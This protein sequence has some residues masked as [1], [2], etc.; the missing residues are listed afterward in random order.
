[1]KQLKAGR[2]RER[3]ETKKR[4]GHN[5][6]EIARKIARATEVGAKFKSETQQ[7]K[8]SVIEGDRKV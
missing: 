5:D 6:I 2:V 3:E 7:E 8:R 4:R 1:M